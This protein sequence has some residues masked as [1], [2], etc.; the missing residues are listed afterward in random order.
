MRIVL[1][2]IMLFVHA[3]LFASPINI[4]EKKT[5]QYFNTIKN[6]PEKLTIFLKKC[7]KELIYTCISVAPL[8]R[9]IC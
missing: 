8:T 7:Q 9:K 3:N 5:S 1:L 2:C 4:A 6:D